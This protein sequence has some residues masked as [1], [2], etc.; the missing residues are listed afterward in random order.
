M[1]GVCDMVRVCGGE[2]SGTEYGRHV[3]HHTGTVTIDGTTVTKGGWGVR[4]RGEGN[5]GFE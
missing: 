3:I 2:V 1:C 5:G 4:G